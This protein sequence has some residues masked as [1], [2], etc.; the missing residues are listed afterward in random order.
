[1]RTHFSAEDQEIVKDCCISRAIQTLMKAYDDCEGVTF[2]GVGL[3]ALIAAWQAFEVSRTTAKENDPIF[4]ALLNEAIKTQENGHELYLSTDQVGIWVEHIGLILTPSFALEAFNYYL[5]TWI[6]PHSPTSG[7]VPYHLLDFDMD[8]TRDYSIGLSF[9]D[10]GEIVF[11]PQ[12]KWDGIV[13]LAKRVFF[14]M[15]AT[16]EKLEAWKAASKGG[17]L[18]FTEICAIRRLFFFFEV[19]TKLQEMQHPQLLTLTK[20]QRASNK[21]KG[22]H[23]T[24]KDISNIL[25]T[26]GPIARPESKVGPESPPVTRS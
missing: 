3:D 23:L 1:M 8:G 6:H 21:K 11:D 7:G 12:M 4:H 22:V 18:A 5:D 16:T 9:D 26:F 17:K 15:I 13:D 10:N 2:A 25:E 20:L 24:A 19:P 14:F